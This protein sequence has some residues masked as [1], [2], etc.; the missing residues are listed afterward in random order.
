MRSY[1]HWAR[2]VVA[3]LNEV[4]WAQLVVKFVAIVWAV[5]ILIVT[6]RVFGLA[7]GDVLVAALSVTMIVGAVV[8]AIGL[9]AAARERNPEPHQLREELDRAIT[10]LGIELAGLLLMTTAALLYALSQFVLMFGD[11]GD[12]RAA[13]TVFACLNIAWTIARVMSVTHRRRR[14]IRTRMS[15]GALL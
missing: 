10:G 13:L 11:Q 1:L 4:D 12:Q 8:S 14:E 6:P 5:T 3:R 9:V 15:V 7:L 2:V